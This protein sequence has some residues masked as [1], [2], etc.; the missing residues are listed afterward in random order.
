MKNG[1]LSTDSA[2]AAATAIVRAC[3]SIFEEAMRAR[4]G[5]DVDWQAAAAAEF[6]RLLSLLRSERDFPAPD[7]PL[8]GG[9][10]G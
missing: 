5:P 9:L 8:P 2:V 3:P 1:K 7:Q 10:G 6:M 4:M